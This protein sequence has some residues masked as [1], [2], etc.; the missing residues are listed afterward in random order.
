MAWRGEERR[1]KKKKTYIV[2]LGGWCVCHVLV[3]VVRQYVN[4]FV[5]W[6]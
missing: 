1:G 3:I 5:D 4:G 6:E 2:S